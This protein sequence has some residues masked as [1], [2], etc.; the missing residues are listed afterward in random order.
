MNRGEIW[1]C[2]FSKADKKRPVVILT[3]QELIP[4]LH[5]VTVAP[6]T[7]T[8]RGVSS[9]VLLGREEGLKETSAIN[10]HHLVTIPQSSLQTFIGSLS[11]AKMEEIREAM[12]FALG[13]EG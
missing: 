8:I 5:T 6:I 10:L 9:E 11:P 12:L 3:R 13:F 1:G 2:E 4:Y 7:R